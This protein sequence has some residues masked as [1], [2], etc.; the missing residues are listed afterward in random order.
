M[1]RIISEG[2]LTVLRHALDRRRELLDAEVTRLRRPEPKRK[3]A[4]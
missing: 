3:P 1:A 4:A 2:Q